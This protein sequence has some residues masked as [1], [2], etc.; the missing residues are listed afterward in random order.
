MAHAKNYYIKSCIAALL[1][2]AT[3]GGTF[4]QNTGFNSGKTPLR[5]NELRFDVRP[6]Y[7]YAVKPEK[8]QNAKFISDVSY[9]FPSNWITVYDSVIITATSKGK[10]KRLSGT[11][12]VLSSDQKTLLSTADLSSGVI[13]HVKY[14]YK[15]PVSQE[16]EN[17]QIRYEMTVVPETEAEYAGGMGQLKDYLKVNAV[18]QLPESVRNQIMNIKVRFTID[19]QGK[20]TN[21]RLLYKSPDPKTDKLL[22]D[23]INQMPDWKPAINL[24]GEHVKQDF[25]FTLGNVSE[26]C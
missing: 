23:A 18:D 2:I 15:N 13:I 6:I 14:K 1:L 5:K 20:V 4:S 16:M 24:K 19:E 21:A 3:A 25:E 7:R 12:P 9:G 17:N 22:L 8:L 10:T 26:G 11:T